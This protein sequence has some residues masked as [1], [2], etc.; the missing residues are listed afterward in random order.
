MIQRLLILLVL[1]GLALSQQ[2]KWQNPY[3]SWNRTVLR[4]P[5]IRNITILDYVFK[6]AQFVPPTVRPSQQSQTDNTNQTPNLRGG[7]VG[8][9]TDNNTEPTFF[10]TPDSSFLQSELL[11]GEFI[12]EN[13][14]DT[15]NSTQ[16]WLP[17][18]ADG[19][20]D[21]GDGEF[22]SSGL[23]N[24]I[25]VDQQTELFLPYFVAVQKVYPARLLID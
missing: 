10:S 15:L 4:G 23:G 21:L 16:W 6:F 5:A 17:S 8:L 9:E 22:T 7:N 14:E 24:G 11:D 20:L 25:I 12:M 2:H 3:T 1:V 19:E 18:L 13:L